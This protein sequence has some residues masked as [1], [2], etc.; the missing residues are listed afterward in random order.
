[1][2]TSK[3]SLFYSL[4]PTKVIPPA[5]REV[6]RK[7]RWVKVMQKTVEAEWK[8]KIIKNTYELFDP[9]IENQKRFFEG[10]V[11][12][13]YAIQDMDLFEGKPDT[14]T[15]DKYREE[16]LDESLG[17]N[18]QTINKI[19]RKR[20]STKDFKE[21]QAWNTFLKTLE[22]TIFAVSGYEFPDSKNFWEL[23]KQYGHEEAKRIAIE[24]LQARLKKRYDK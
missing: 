7:E 15:L 23:V 24:Q 11:V 16:I 3:I 2:K 10:A 1:M 13:Y 17:Y 22:E 19:L 12:E 14:S 20:K 6:E 9:E 21:V 18:F 4:T 5:E 8:P